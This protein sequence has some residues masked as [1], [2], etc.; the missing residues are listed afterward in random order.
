M[1]TTEVLLPL[2][3]EGV[4]EASVVSWLVA[5]GSQVSKDAPILEVATDKVDTEIVAPSDGYLIKQLV[6]EGDTV[7]VNQVLGLIGSSATEK[8]SQTSLKETSQPTN[9]VNKVSSGPYQL[10]MNVR[11]NLMTN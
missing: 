5:E 11:V 6:T 4:N 1:A 2:M 7:T 3:G 9:Q 8:I 10:F